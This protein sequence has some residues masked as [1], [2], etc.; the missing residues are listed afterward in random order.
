[1][2]LAGQTLFVAGPPDV[3]NEE[4]AVKSLDNPN[5]RAKLAEQG[6]AYKG[7]GPAILTAV[8]ATD[9]K[10]LVSY[11]LAAAPVFDGMAAAGGKLYLSTVD[12]KVLCLGSGPGT[13]LARAADV[14]VTPRPDADKPLTT[15]PVQPSAVKRRARS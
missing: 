6:A 13:P 5:L 4:E 10:G 9:G 12:G 3:V 1:M 11:Q 14:I 15:A 8:S 2:V 7:H